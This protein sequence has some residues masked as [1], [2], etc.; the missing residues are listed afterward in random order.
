MQQ[1]RLLA[2]DRDLADLPDPAAGH[3]GDAAIE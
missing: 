2:L 1:H 3:P